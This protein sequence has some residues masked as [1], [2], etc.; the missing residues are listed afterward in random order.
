[1]E[2]IKMDARTQNDKKSQYKLSKCPNVKK[3]AECADHEINVCGYMYYTDTTANSETAKMILT[4]VDGE[5][6]VYGTNSK[7]AQENFNDILTFFEDDLNE[8]GFIPVRVT[9]NTSKNNRTFIQLEY[10]G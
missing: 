2:I 9:S 5:G 1:M 8:C 6:N 3:L 7:T 10:C 4:L